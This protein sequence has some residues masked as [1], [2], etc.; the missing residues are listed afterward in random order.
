MEGGEGLPGVVVSCTN[1]WKCGEKSGCRELSKAARKC[2]KCGEKRG[3]RGLPRN[4][5]N[6]LGG[7]EL[8]RV[9]VSC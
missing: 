6:G 5:V 7:E 1:Y 3:Y 4:G 2:P 9:V 8:S